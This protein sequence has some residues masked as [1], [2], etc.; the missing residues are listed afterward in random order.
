MALGTGTFRR[1]VVPPALDTRLL[2]RLPSAVI[3]CDPQSLVIRYA[4]GRSMR[5]L[6][7]IS[8]ALPVKPDALIG[9][10]LETFHPA[11]A[12]QR[13]QILAATDAA[14]RMVVK[15]KGETL[16]FH[17][18]ALRDARGQKSYLQLTW[19]VTTDLVA[20]ETEVNLLRQMVDDV[21][22]NI[23][24]CDPHDFRIDYAN[25]AAME[26]LRRIERYLPVTA[27]TLVGSSIDVFHKE[28]TRWRALLSDPRNLPHQARIR[29][30]EES[31]DLRI[32][33]ITNPDGSYAG[34]MLT[35]A[36]VT[37]HVQVANGLSEVVGSMTQTSEAVHA[38]SE[39]L[40][41][42]TAT[43]GQMVSNVSESAVQMSN[44]FDE[45]SDRLREALTMSQETAEKADSTDEIVNSLANSVKRIG[46]VTALIEKIASQTN[47]LALNATIE[48]ARVGAAGKGFEVVAQEVKA[49]AVQ[50]A[51]ATKDIRAQIGAVQQASGEATAAVSEITQNVS[52]LTSVF[53]SITSGMTVQADAN[54]G[55]SESIDGVSRASAEIRDAAGGVNTVAGEVSG[56]AE[57]LRREVRALLEKKS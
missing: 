51:G 2:D 52:R 19:N 57:K 11:F 43:S 8:Q 25:K 22:V 7:R 33:A 31:L 20:E 47:L 16:E 18:G 17:V 15:L 9:S 56:F 21:P 39:R 41:G 50:T 44:A 28:P 24:T 10:P 23:M 4:N 32:T 36:L 6:E 5:L 40:L 37:E 38:S 35:W 46:A 12:E 30:G 29:V 42:L 1:D 3:L 55:V 14:H 13:A 34:P 54:R 48:A 45:I 49:L 26:T 53:K 27:D